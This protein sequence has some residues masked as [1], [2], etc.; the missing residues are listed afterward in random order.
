MT[1][2]LTQ[3]E[4]FLRVARGEMPE[5]VPVA[6]LG[7]PDVAPLMT[8]ADPA[9]IGSFRGP[10]GG[11]DPWGVTFVTSEEINFA[12]LPK[13]NDFILTDVTKWR[14][15]LKAPDYSGFDWEAAAKADR[16]KYIQDPD[17]TAYVL[18]GYADIFQQF[19]GF[20]GF[21]EGL[22]AIY[23]E[24]EEVEELFDYLLEH[25]LYI[26]KNLLHYYKPEG[27]YLLDDTAS[28]LQPFI[29][30]SVFKELLVP[31]Y[32]KC[33]DLVRE[34][35]VPIFY[36]NC[37]RCED[38]IPPMVDIGV[39]VWDPAQVQNDLVAI[40]EKFGPKLAINGGFEFNMPITWP[41]ID[42]EE[43]R[44]KVRST[45]KKL[46]HDGGFIF[47]GMIT[48]LDWMD[49]KIQEVNGWIADEANKLSKTIY[50]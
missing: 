38:L 47:S 39:N 2:H 1:T 22:C 23:E 34:E 25:S 18:S 45:F 46:A 11:I 13:P 50:N 4:N 5:Y 32:K 37:G 31:R 33:L 26:T 29:S 16:K 35:E 3:K 24:R 48:S 19:I 20:M 15:V 6:T 14:D 8:M 42:E 10:G 12:A 17:K 44:E 28:K 30:P 21:T 7:G 43:V 49:P 27:Y 36:H 41:V 40:K 9:I